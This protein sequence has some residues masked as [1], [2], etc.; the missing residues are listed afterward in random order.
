MRARDASDLKSTFLSRITSHIAETPMSARRA[1]E[2]MS[3]TRTTLRID[4]NI[5]LGTSGTPAS[6]PT[7]INLLANRTTTATVARS[8]NVSKDFQIT[9]LSNKS[10]IPS[11]EIPVRRMTMTMKNKETEFLIFFIKFIKNK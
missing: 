5:G 10:Q 2:A 3:T 8:P 1:A 6:E 7:F 9:S 4:L 11:T